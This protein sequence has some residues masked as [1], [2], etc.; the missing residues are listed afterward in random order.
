M[1]STLIRYE[2]GAWAEKNESAVV[3]TFRRRSRMLAESTLCAPY[4]TLG[5]TGRAK[6]KS[7]APT[8]QTLHATT[9]HCLQDYEVH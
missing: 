4:G 2:I 1:A 3:Y 7:Q 6:S 5:S 8:S 9:V